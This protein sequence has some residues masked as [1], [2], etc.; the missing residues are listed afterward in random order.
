M[1]E[2]HTQDHDYTNH[3]LYKL[4]NVTAKPVSKS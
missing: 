4:Y 1:N 2:S 3:I